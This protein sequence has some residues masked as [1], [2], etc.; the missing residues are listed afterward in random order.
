ML[1][2]FSS[3]GMS[4]NYLPSDWV[5]YTPVIIV[6]SVI[7]GIVL[8]ALVWMRGAKFV[9]QVKQKWIGWRSTTE[10]DI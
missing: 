8:V 2:A 7:V 10:R 1:D 9:E 5:Y 6:S 4:S 3:S